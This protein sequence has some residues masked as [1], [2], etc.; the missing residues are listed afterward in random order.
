M[1]FYLDPFIDLK[2]SFRELSF[3]PPTPRIVHA[4]HCHWRRSSEMTLSYF[5][6][7]SY[8]TRNIHYRERE[9]EKEGK[10]KNKKSDDETMRK[11]S[12][13]EV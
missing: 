9:G 5:S 7:F 3:T 13:N 2:L 8:K 11:S 1:T 12:G 6:F 10:S 4:L